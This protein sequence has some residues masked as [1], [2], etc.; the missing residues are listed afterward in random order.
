MYVD[1]IL[2]W[3]TEE[4]RMLE[5]GT[6]ITNIGVDL[7]EENDCANFLGVNLQ[8][9]GNQMISQT[10]LI[11]R[12]IEAMGLNVDL[13][14]GRHTLCLK[15]PLSK[16]LEGDL[17]SWSFEYASVIGM[18]LCLSCHSRPDIAYS[19]SQCARFT[20]APKCSH[21]E[22]LKRIGHYLFETRTKGLIITPT[23]ELNIEGYPDADFSC[24]WGYEGF[25]DPIRVRSR[26]RFVILV[27]GCLV[28]WKSQLQ[29]EISTSTMHSEVIDLGACTRELIPVV[30]LVEEVGAAVVMT[31]KERTCLHIMVHEDNDGALV[32]AQPAPPP[33]Y[34]CL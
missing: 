24:L 16:D 12:V 29:T 19:V 21:E 17:C 9:T 15:A 27:P 31:P 22:S 23:R 28:L 2:M 14:T 1:D 20:F 25:Y 30:D 33:V 18:I 32:L 6:N 13:S 11:D 4:S 26:T 5:L 8:K 7:E 3:S 10:G 34:D